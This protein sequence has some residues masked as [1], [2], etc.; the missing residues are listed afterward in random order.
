MLMG[1]KINNIYIKNAKALLI[2]SKKAE[3][4][5]NPQKTKYQIIKYIPSCE[6]PLLVSTIIPSCPTRLS[7]LTPSPLPALYN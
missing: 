5:V 7:P 1:E 6:T 4:K 3:L 2:T